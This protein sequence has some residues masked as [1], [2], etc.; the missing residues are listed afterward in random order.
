MHPTFTWCVTRTASC[1]LRVGL[2]VGCRLAAGDSEMAFTAALHTYFAVSAIE[3][4]T[5]EGLSGVTYSD[6]LAGGVSVVQEGPVMFDREVDRIY[7][8][9]PDAAMKV[10][11]AGSCGWVVREFADSAVSVAKHLPCP[12]L[13]SLLHTHTLAYLALLALLCVYKLL[14]AAEHAP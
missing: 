6:S 3:G 2:F 12:G 13:L 14:T 1:S 4:V 8:L 5:V 9:A 10:S 7:L 11:R